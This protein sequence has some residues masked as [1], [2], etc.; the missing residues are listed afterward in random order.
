VNN[1]AGGGA[2]FQGRAREEQIRDT[3]SVWPEFIQKKTRVHIEVA[4]RA[5][6]RRYMWITAR[7]G[8]YGEVVVKLGPNPHMRGMNSR[9]EKN[10]TEGNR[11]QGEEVKLRTLLALF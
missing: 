8:N 9:N 5:T 10:T 3:L 1:N 4:D 2:T 6:A 7:G 11:G